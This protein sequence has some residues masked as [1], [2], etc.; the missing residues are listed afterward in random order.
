MKIKIFDSTLRDGIQGSNIDFSISDKI[1]IVKAFDDFGIDYIEAGNPF[2]NPKDIEFFKLAKDIKL[3]HSKL[4]AFGSTCRKNCKPQDDS[5]V[6]TL[7][8][9]CTEYVS[10]FG[11]TSIFHVENILG[12]TKEENL[13]MINETVEYLKSKN[14]HIFFD[15]EHF[16]DGFKSNQDYAIECLLT[17][18]NAGAE[19]A[20]L[21]DTNGGTFPNEIEDAIKY[22]SS[23]L[24]IPIGIHCHNDN[25]C[26]CAN[27]ISAVK[28]GATQV[29][30]TFAG[31]GERCGN[32]NLSSLIPNLK[33][34]LGYDCLSDESISKITEITRFIAEVA[35][36][37]LHNNM[38]FVG[39]NAFSHKAGMHVDA[40]LKNNSSFEHIPPES[41][42]NTRSFIIS[43]VSGRTTVLSKLQ[44]LAPNIT[45]DSSELA[46]ILNILKEQQLKGY[47]YEAAEASF[48]LLVLKYLGMFKEFFYINYFKII[49]E[50]SGD[51]QK[52]ATAMVKVRVDDKFEIAADEGDGPVNALD[53]ALRSALSHFYPDIINEIQLVDYKVRVMNTGAGTGAIVRVLIESSDGINNWTTVG[54]STDII[55]ASVKAL[56]DSIEYKLYKSTN[57][58]TEVFLWQ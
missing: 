17:A 22:V 14:K 39:K 12:T 44:K 23:K 27:S 32:T 43:E 55:N 31:I 16:F 34:K 21:C 30:G 45:R 38:P 52:A 25:D 7:S 47:L 53:K 49:G 58:K 10:I 13:R 33:L 18:Q 57:I 36:I 6:I 9:V 40:V 3:K 24:S 28:S 29:Q 26:A 1:K 46:D 5:N 19:Y 48:D 37:S 20:I 54:A 50:Q 51:L 41:V 11:K 4:V 2:S 8:E 15:A 35:N 56:V 42:G